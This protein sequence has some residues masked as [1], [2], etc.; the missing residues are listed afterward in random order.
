MI[1]HLHH[2]SCIRHFFTDIH[3]VELDARISLL[4]FQLSIQLN[5]LD[6]AIDILI[7]LNAFF[8]ANE[9][10]AIHLPNQTYCPVIDMRS[11]ANEMQL[12]EFVRQQHKIATHWTSSS[13]SMGDGKRFDDTVSMLMAHRRCNFASKYL[14]H[15]QQFEILMESLWHTKRFNECLR[16]C[17]IGLNAAMRM[18]TTTTAKNIEMSSQFSRHVRFLTTYLEHLLSNNRLRK[19]FSMCNFLNAFLS[20]LVQ[21]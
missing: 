12:M 8:L 18:W 17:E 9:M 7:Q 19:Y 14:C 15:F 16:W 4:K 6:Q 20:V 1:Q 21:N 10:H 2:I 13:S 5:D 11:I 3:D